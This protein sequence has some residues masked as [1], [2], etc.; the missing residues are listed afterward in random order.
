MELVELLETAKAKAGLPSDYA[1][2]K[3]ININRSNICAWRDGTTLPS[4]RAIA[5]LA[6]T[7]AD[8]PAKWLI[9]LNIERS[10]SDLCRASYE[11]IMME[12]LAAR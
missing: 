3:T 5:A 12:H 7:A 8:D 10:A 11:R 1:L 2:A 6:A 4:D 9:W